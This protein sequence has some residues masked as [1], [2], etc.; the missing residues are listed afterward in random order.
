MPPY[1]W[2]PGPSHL[3]RLISKH[4]PFILNIYLYIFSKNSLVGCPPAGCPGPSHL[5]APPSAR[6]CLHYLPSCWTCSNNFRNPLF[7]KRVDNVMQKLFYSVAVPPQIIADISSNDVTVNEGETVVLKCNVTGVPHPDV[8][9]FRRP[10]NANT[11]PYAPESR[12][13]T[14]LWHQAI[15]IQSLEQC[16]PAVCRGTQVDRESG[17]SNLKLLISCIRPRNTSTTPS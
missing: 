5:P 16:F 13:S 8:T 6:H 11:W 15:L 1:P 9:W 17:N 12:S 2:C 7:C 10:A 14:T 4:L 3:F